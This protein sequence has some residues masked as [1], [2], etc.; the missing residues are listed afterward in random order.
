MTTSLAQYSQDKPGMHEFWVRTVIFTQPFTWKVCIG[1]MAWYNSCLNSRVVFF[2]SV[3]RKAGKKDWKQALGAHLSVWKVHFLAVKQ[4][5]RH[6]YFLL[7]SKPQE[8]LQQYDSV[9]RTKYT[10]WS[11]EMC[12]FFWLLVWEV[13]FPFH[14]DAP[15][16]KP[17]HLRNKMQDS[18][19]QAVQQNPQQES[20]PKTAYVD[21]QIKSGHG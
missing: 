12:F 2:S 20:K 8:E 16:H 15:H 10:K 3:I 1:C 17:H 6:V 5:I 13:K 21:M 9:N 19:L 14:K 11:G 7:K 18:V 4:I